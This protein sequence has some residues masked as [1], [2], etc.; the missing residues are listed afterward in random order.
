MADDITL[1]IG[2]DTGAVDKGTEQ[3]KAKLDDLA[4]HVNA[5]Q[6]GFNALGSEIKDGFDEVE[7]G[8]GS[9]ND[10]FKGLNETIAKGGSTL[11]TGWMKLL[12]G[13]GIG[14][15]AAGVVKVFHDVNEEFLKMET[16]SREA[17][18]SLERFQELQYALSKGG[19]GGDKFEKSLEEA[20][21][22]LNELTHDSGELG[23]FLDENNVKWKD[24]KDNII[25][26]NEYIEVAARLI[27]NA[28]SQG[29]RFKAGELLGFSKEWVRVLQDGPIALRQATEEAH[30]VGAVFTDELVRK[31]ADFEREWNAASHR[32]A[33][34]FKAVLAD[35]LPYIAA[36]IDALL[37]ALGYVTKIATD[38]GGAFSKMVTEG[39][40]PAQAAQNKMATDTGI[41]A[42][43]MGALYETMRNMG[44]VSNT[45]EVTWNKMVADAAAMSKDMQ[46]LLQ[47]SFPTKDKATKF[48]KDK[49]EGD[50]DTRAQLAKI[51]QQ[52][53]AWREYYQKLVIYEKNQVDTFKQTEGQK[54]SHLLEALAQEE[55]AVK[56]LYDK[57]VAVVGD[58]SNKIAEIRRK[59]ARTIEAIH[60]QSL[61]LQTEQL[62]KSAQ[63][64]QSVL[65]TV[66]SAFESQLRG[67]LA[68]TTTWS[69]AMKNIA[70][71]LVLKIISEFLKLAVIKPLAG[72]L[73]SMM[74]APTELFASF[75]KMIGGLFGPLSAGFTSFFAPT[76]GPA[77][78]AAGAAAAGA[79][80][81]A[82]TATVGAFEM[83]TDY[84][85]RTGLALVHQG[86]RIIP[87]SQ[88][89]TGGGLGPQAHFAFNIS[90]LD[91]TGVQAFMTRY[92][93]Q[94]AR[95]M[96]AHM[97]QNP[98]FQS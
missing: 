75:V 21:K 61:E 40:G 65:Q 92:M 27:S 95:M 5:L 30:K 42:G 24:A 72:A 56:A 83:G 33:I 59:E 73:S 71:D 45:T 81:A 62:R 26:M 50:D 97:A 70:A 8:L 43:T 34:E 32:W 22:K 77:A 2:A 18:I 90:A 54:I 20:A 89:M 11:D 82:A 41:M 74:A 28:A 88:N 91:A 35:L 98:S 15:A 48:P 76:L 10:A 17:T 9:L 55:A 12:L 39:Y 58:D 51:N 14:G 87:A 60:K 49:D 3:V 13:A 66:S 29:D 38:L 68:R 94:I 85:P 79:E 47:E 64:W 36:L 63:E 57:E 53:D 52:L 25:G 6:S 19:A 16:T 4:T 46:R 67:L 93:P 44:A 80:V 69:Q 96:A 78:P 7:K 86:E 84:V 23:K 37:K 31:S 1:K